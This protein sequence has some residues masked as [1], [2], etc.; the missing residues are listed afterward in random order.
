MKVKSCKAKGAVIWRKHQ[1]MKRE[2]TFNNFKTDRDLL[3][4]IY[5][6]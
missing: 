2:K 1:P 3:P 5:K 6:N 4:K